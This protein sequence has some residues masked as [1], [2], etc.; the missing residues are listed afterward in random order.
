MLHKKKEE[1]LHRIDKEFVISK[2]MNSEDIGILN[3]LRKRFEG[4]LE[5]VDRMKTEYCQISHEGKRCFD[6][7]IQKVRDA[8]ETAQEEPN[9]I[10]RY[11]F[12]TC[13]MDA[14]FKLIREGNI[15]LA[16]NGR[17]RLVQF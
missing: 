15:F 5:C 16:D 14:I 6:E 9:T 2:T 8:F 7:S 3:S 1:V 17:D 11:K 13:I 4:E 12:K 10:H